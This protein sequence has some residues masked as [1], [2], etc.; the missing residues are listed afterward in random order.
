M[1]RVYL[2]AVY[3]A[4]RKEVM[5][6]R[7]LNGAVFCS[8]GS[9]G[10]CSLIVEFIQEFFYNAATKLKGTALVAYPVHGVLLKTLRGNRQWPVE[11]ELPLVGFLTAKM[12]TYMESEPCDEGRGACAHNWF[13]RTDEVRAKESMM[14]LEQKTLMQLKTG[15]LPKAI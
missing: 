15:L 5:V 6:I 9:E 10:E 11:N 2:R 3:S 14:P 13:N 12:E 4:V 1:R 8:E 7:N